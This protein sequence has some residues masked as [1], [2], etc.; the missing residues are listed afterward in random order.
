MTQRTSPRAT[1]EALRLRLVGARQAIAREALD[2]QD[3]NALNSL[4][5]DLKDIQEQIEALDRA[6]ADEAAA[7]PR[8]VG[9]TR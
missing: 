5:K 1:L 7:E 2:T 3:G 8:S 6:R 4:A 9:F